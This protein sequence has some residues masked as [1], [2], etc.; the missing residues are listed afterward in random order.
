M[1]EQ[2][3]YLTDQDRAVELGWMAAALPR[4]IDERFRQLQGPAREW[5]THSG[6]PSKEAAPWLT[7]PSL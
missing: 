7:C 1:K 5:L 6:L 3:T 2:G 4:G